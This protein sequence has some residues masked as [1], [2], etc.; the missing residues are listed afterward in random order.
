[1]LRAGKN[2]AFA[3]LVVGQRRCQDIDAA[4]LQ[5]G[6]AGCHRQLLDHRLHAQPFGDL[7]AQ[8][9]FVTDQLARLGIDKAVRLVGAQRAA[10]Q[11]ALSLDGGQLVG[12]RQLGKRDGGQ[13]K[14][15]KVKT[16][17]HGNPVVA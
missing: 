5:F 13:D 3:L 2:Q 9:H 4:L 8:I 11:F 16:G 10:D 14:C 6:N 12:M 15:G 17:L 7:A 1:M